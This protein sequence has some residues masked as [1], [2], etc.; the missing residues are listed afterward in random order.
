MKLKGSE[1]HLSL[2]LLV[3][4]FSILDIKLNIP[5]LCFLIC[6]FSILNQNQDIM[7]L[8]RIFTL[9][10]GKNCKETS[11]LQQ[12]QCI[13]TPLHLH[14]CKLSSIQKT[15]LE[16]KKNIFSFS[17][18]CPLGCKSY[19]DFFFEE[20]KTWIPCFDFFSFL[21]SFKQQMEH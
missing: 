2:F 5:L 12:W 9:S 11:R 20:I 16:M 14:I 6:S 3:Y 4:K 1:F 21:Y 13:F 8:L 19:F 7:M 15:L 18:A 10:G 17:D